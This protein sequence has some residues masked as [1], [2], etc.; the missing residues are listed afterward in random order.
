MEEER[1]EREKEE[2]ERRV[3]ERMKKKSSI[4][5]EKNFHLTIPYRRHSTTSSSLEVST[6]TESE[7]FDEPTEMMNQEVQG[8]VSYNTA[9]SE[10]ES[11]DN[12]EEDGSKSDDVLL[13]PEEKEK[14][15]RSPLDVSLI[16]NKRLCPFGKY[17][18]AKGAKK[19]RNSKV[20]TLQQCLNVIHEVYE[21]K[22]IA[23]AEDRRAGTVSM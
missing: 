6:Q 11:Q 2:R 20:M 22:C 5:E 17:L 12:E 8:N 23:D 9:I 19:Y 10:L 21:K 1:K 4:R 14:K 3:I 16:G 7:Y 13:V 18:G 15:P